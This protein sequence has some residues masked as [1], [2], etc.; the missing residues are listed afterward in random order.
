MPTQS[1]VEDCFVCCRAIAISYTADDGELLA[2][3]ADSEC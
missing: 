1:Y 3:T 2:V